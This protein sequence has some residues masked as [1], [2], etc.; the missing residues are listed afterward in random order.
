MNSPI[1]RY[2]L[3][4]SVNYNFPTLITLFEYLPL[5]SPPLTARK[6]LK[7]RSGD[8]RFGHS[9]RVYISSTGCRPGPAACMPQPLLYQE[10]HARPER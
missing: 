7:Q 10:H 4:L 3:N 1:I 2:Q 5:T 9:L 6:S 8:F